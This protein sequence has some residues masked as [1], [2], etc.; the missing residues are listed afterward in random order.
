[1]QRSGQDSVVVH[2]SVDERVTASVVSLFT[3]FSPDIH[4]DSQIH[5]LRLDVYQHT[6]HCQISI[7]RKPLPISSL[8]GFKLP[9]L[10]IH[11]DPRVFLSR[12]GFEAVHI[13]NDIGNPVGTFSGKEGGE[14]GRRFWGE[15]CRVM[16]WGV[17]RGCDEFGSGNVKFVGSAKF[18]CR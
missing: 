12:S 18:G 2:Q 16:S 10:F 5:L 13:M 6:P 15:R 9:R 1:L 4:L 14:P 7:I 17:R 11:L 8:T 3:C